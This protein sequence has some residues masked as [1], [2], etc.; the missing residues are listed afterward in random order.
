MKIKTIPQEYEAIQFN[1][2]TQDVI[3]FIL[4]TDAK[5]YKS[6]EDFVLS[7]VIGNHG[8]NIGDYLYKYDS[9]LTMIGIAHNDTI[10]SKYFEVVN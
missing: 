7:N 5:I 4:N 1:G 10:F 6:S 3:D 9:S 2:L 8:L